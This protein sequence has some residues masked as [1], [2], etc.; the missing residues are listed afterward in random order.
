MNEQKFVN[1]VIGER[2]VMEARMAN[3]ESFCY[4]AV[5]LYKS[6]SDVPGYLP[7]YQECFVLIKATSIEKAQEKALAHGNQEQVT[8]QNENQETITWSFEQLIDVNVV[9][10]DQLDD[11]SELYARHFRNYE[12]YCKFEPMLLG[13]I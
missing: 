4:I 5:I 10:D 7:L 3:E 12:A 6:T 1:I 13:E 9:L 11:G 8:Y 2:V